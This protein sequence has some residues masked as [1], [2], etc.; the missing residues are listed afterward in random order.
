MFAGSQCCVKDFCSWLF[1]PEHRGARV[2]AHNLQSYDAYF[3]LQ[4]AYKEMLIPKLIVRDSKALSMRF[5]EHDIAFID[6]LNFIPLPLPGFRKAFG[7]STELQKDDF[8]HRFNRTENQDYVGPMPELHW[9]HPDSK[10]P[11]A[12][13]KLVE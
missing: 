11:E 13:T 2:V 8:P 12:R 6:S 7:L 4:E 5:E 9:Y 1:T 3:V 10:K